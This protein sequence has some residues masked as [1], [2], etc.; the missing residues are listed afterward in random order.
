MEE[1]EL[2]IKLLKENTFPIF[3]LKNVYVSSIG[4]S[5]TLQFHSCTI[6]TALVDEDLKATLTTVGEYWKKKQTEVEEVSQ[7]VIFFKEI[8]IH[9]RTKK[10]YTLPHKKYVITFSCNSEQ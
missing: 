1:K 5:K 7:Y 10:N 4:V 6:S 3:L 8:F 2:L 9:F